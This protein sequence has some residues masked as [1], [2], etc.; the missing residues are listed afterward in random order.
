MVALYVAGVL[1]GLVIIAIAL[2][3]WVRQSGKRLGGDHNQA[4]Q[5]LP[6][7]VRD[8]DP[9]TTPGA[10]DGKNRHRRRPGPT[11]RTA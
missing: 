7:I 9:S 6:R 10:S 2:A 11:A 3:G 1:S 4:P 8:T 5:G